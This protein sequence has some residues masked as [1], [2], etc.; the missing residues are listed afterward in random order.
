[1][2]HLRVACR[3][4][5]DPSTARKRD[6]YFLVARTCGENREQFHNVEH[7][8]ILRMES[9]RRKL[10]EQEPYM[11]AVEKPT[12][13]SSAST[14]TVP[15]P[16]ES[17][18]RRDRTH[19]ISAK[20]WTLERLLTQSPTLQPVKRVSALSERDMLQAIAEHETT[21]E[22]LIIEDW[23]KHPKWPSEMFSMDWLVATKGHEGEYSLDSCSNG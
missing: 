21:G 19:S 9:I 10:M 17:V 23:H 22:P 1:M 12:S 16:V 14:S 3:H 2:S 4:V 5:Q 11:Y 8:H 6:T 15:G 13:V 20:A 7:L 18:S